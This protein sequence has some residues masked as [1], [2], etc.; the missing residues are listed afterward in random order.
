[1]FW[2]CISIVIGRTSLVFKSLVF[3]LWR[4]GIWWRFLCTVRWG[5]PSW[6]AAAKGL[7]SCSGSLLQPHGSSDAASASI[8]HSRSSEH[9][10]WFLWRKLILIK[11]STLF[12]FSNTYNLK[13]QNL[14]CRRIWA[15]TVYWQSRVLHFEFFFDTPDLGAQSIGYI[16][17]TRPSYIMDNTFGIF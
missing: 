6:P 1:M 10:G 2:Y 5:P 8:Y 15:E 17:D 13:M 9:R 4:S 14:L 3:S 12:F 11:V 7:G 16:V